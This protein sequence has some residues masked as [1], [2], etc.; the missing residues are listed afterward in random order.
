[1]VTAGINSFNAI[2]CGVRC[3][4]AL[5]R[6][7]QGGRVTTSIWRLQGAEL[8][9]GVVGGGQI[10]RQHGRAQAMREEGDDR[11]GPPFS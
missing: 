3:G 10:Q 5:R 6:G 2:E 8:G 11:W 4:G 9:G 1:V 7:N